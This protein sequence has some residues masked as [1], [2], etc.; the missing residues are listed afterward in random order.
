[1]VKVF[2]IFVAFLENINFINTSSFFTI[3]GDS[4]QL[5]FQGINFA[6][7]QILILILNLKGKTLVVVVNF[8]YEADP[9]QNMFFFSFLSALLNWRKNPNFFKIAVWGSNSMKRNYGPIPLNSRIQ[10]NVLVSDWK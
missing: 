4:D 3:K 2:S 10:P 8:Q 7:Q 5:G 6:I 9:K 1:M